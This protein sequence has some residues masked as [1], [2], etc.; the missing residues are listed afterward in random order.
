MVCFQGTSILEKYIF[1]LSSA[2]LHGWW[3]CLISTLLCCV[4]LPSRC[5]H[6]CWAVVLPEPCQMNPSTCYLE[7][8]ILSRLLWWSREL[9]AWLLGPG[10]GFHMEV[11]MCLFVESSFITCVSNS[12]LDRLYDCALKHRRFSA[13]LLVSFWSWWFQWRLARYLCLSV[14]IEEGKRATD[15]LE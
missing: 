12:I 1:W 9:G 8:G 14:F 11:L 5:S 6:K 2:I 4:S 3:V 10:G 15:W 13:L 7:G